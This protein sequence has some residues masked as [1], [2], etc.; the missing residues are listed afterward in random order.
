MDSESRRVL[1][2]EDDKNLTLINRR[3]LQTEGYAVLTAP[4][5]ATARELLARQSFD[6]ILLDVKMPD[7]NGFD[8]CREIRETTAAYIVFLTSVTEPA[9]E[10]EGLRAGGNDYLRKPYG[11]ELLRERIKK[12]VPRER[13][14]ARLIRRGSLALDMAVAKAFVNEEDLQLSQ[15]EFGLLL[16]LVQNEGRVMR[17]EDLYRA[18]W[19][20]P[21][22]DDSNAVK[23]AVYRL[24]K[25][26]KLGG[27][28]I[29]TE[30]GEGY[31][32]EKAE[33]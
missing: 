28:G 23:N 30:Y 26:I 20:L 25:K 14:A 6:V 11:I 15:K 29:A 2:V 12:A 27:Y 5:L 3:A 13:D 10:L 1:I 9:G 33:E 21:M 8:F 7:G 24:R 16:L 18:V 4:T 22:N 32:F 31:R 17:A 19:G